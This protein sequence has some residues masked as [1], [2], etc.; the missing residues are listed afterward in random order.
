[1]NIKNRTTL[2]AIVYTYLIT[3]GLLPDDAKRQVECMT[4]GQ[5]EKFT[6]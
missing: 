2:E 6:E 3:E 1:M 4:D 5:L